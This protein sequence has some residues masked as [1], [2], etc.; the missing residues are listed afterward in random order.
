[1]TDSNRTAIKMVLDRSGSMMSIKDATE[2]AIRGY[3]DSQKKLPG[4]VT[5]AISQ[6]DDVYEVVNASI[7]PDQIPPYVLNPR[8]STALLDAVGRAATEFGEE[9]A[10]LPESQRPGHVFLVIATDGLENASQEYTLAQVKEIITR[11]QDVYGWDVI[12]LAANQDA[13]KEGAKMGMRANSSM[14]YAATPEGTKAVIASASHYTGSSVRT[15]TASFTD[16]D[17]KKAMG[18]Q[19]VSK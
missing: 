9:L 10:A 3:V 19:K 13:I 12:Y 14:T 15:G 17:R 7:P 4:Q 2:E 16:E 18:P 1:M 6:F 11:Q 5:I 8:G